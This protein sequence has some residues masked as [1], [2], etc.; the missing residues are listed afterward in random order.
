MVVR[1]P[2]IVTGAAVIEIASNASLFVNLAKEEAASPIQF[3]I[4]FD[5]LIKLKSM[6]Y[7]VVR[8]SFL[9]SK[10]LW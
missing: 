1:D 5:I 3:Q 9:D 7:L 8:S 10:N 6:I 2:V 4:T